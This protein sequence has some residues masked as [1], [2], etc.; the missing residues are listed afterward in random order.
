MTRGLVGL[1]L[2]VV[3]FTIAFG[4][5]SY[6]Q[7]RRT[8]STGFIRPRRDAPPVEK[9]ASSLFVAAIVLLAAGPIAD[10]AGA[11][12]FGALDSTAIAVL[13]FVIAAAGIALTTG[14]QLSMGDSWRI[15]VD[16]NERTELV[17][18]GMFG[19][20]RNPIFTAMMLA[21]IGLALL[22]PNWWSFAAVIVLVL[23]LELQ[24]RLVEEPYL[25]SR[26]GAAYERYQRDAGRFVPG[27]GKA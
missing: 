21:S 1:T 14:A 5:R 20:V 17:T 10:L 9:L 4:V 18:S 2:E 16:P 24:V 13:G 3:F 23:G 22:V 25:R 6:V 7:W 15:G 11:V 19:L 8:G 26:H 27:L 12:R